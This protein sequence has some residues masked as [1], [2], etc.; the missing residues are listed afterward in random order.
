MKLAYIASL[1]YLFAAVLSTASAGANCALAASPDIVRAPA[2][3]TRAAEPCSVDELAVPI[4]YGEKRDHPP[5]AATGCVRR[6]TPTPHR[7]WKAWGD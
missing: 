5:S 7:P 2:P 6:E 1:A 4:P 3:E